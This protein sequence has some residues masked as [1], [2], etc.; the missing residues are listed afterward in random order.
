MRRTAIALCSSLII[1]LAPRPGWS[2]GTTVI[3][4]T[5]SEPGL[6]TLDISTRTMRDLVNDGKTVII[7]SRSQAEFDAGHI[8]GAHPL[9]GAGTAAVDKLVAGNKQIPLVLY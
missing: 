7:D 3:D 4:A 1:L 8:P 2:Q 5:L 9:A 6:L